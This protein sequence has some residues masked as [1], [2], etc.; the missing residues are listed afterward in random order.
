MV[1]SLSEDEQQVSPAMVRSLS[2]DEQQVSPAMVRSLSE[3]E[4]QVSPAMVRSL[5][6]DEQ[7][8]SPAMVRLL[9]EDEQ[10]VS[11]AM[12]RLLSE[13]EQQVNEHVKPHTLGMGTKWVFSYSY[14]ARSLTLSFLWLS[15]VVAGPEHMHLHQLW[16]TDKLKQK[17]SDLVQVRHSDTTLFQHLPVEDRK[18]AHYLHSH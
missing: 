9:S 16:L 18:E 13:D 7:Q 1:R 17:H 15:L 14:T 10:Q 6:D 12:V 5:S 11:P 8:V 3:D 2:E 4:Q